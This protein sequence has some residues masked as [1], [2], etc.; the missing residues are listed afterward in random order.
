MISQAPDAL[1]WTTIIRIL[2]LVMLYMLIQKYVVQGPMSEA[3][4]A[5]WHPLVGVGFRNA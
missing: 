3:V 5:I 2:P 1:G 4:G